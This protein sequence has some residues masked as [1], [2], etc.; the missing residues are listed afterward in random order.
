MLTE[1]ISTGITANASSEKTTKS[2]EERKAEFMFLYYT[3]PDLA[4]MSTLADLGLADRD[5]RIIAHDIGISI[6]TAEEWKSNLL[7]FGIWFYNEQNK[8]ECIPFF[9]KDDSP[10]NYA[11]RMLRAQSLLDPNGP[12]S[13]RMGTI[14]TNSELF[15]TLIRNLKK[16]Y[17]EFIN[18]S[19][20]LDKPDM[21]VDVSYNV[22]DVLESKKIWQQKR[23]K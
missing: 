2:F 21:I 11:I 19:E 13:Y 12:C 23:L 18:N 4:H 16:S 14:S 9:S 3:N 10:E 20:S 5:I 7:E 15:L 22:I 1:P 17:D 6:K 8:I